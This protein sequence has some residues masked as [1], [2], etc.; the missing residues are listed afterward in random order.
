MKVYRLEHR[1]FGK[2]P[3][4]A[5]SEDPD[6]GAAWELAGEDPMMASPSRPAPARDLGFSFWWQEK[7]RIRFRC[8]YSDL[9]FGCE[10][11]DAL[12]EWFAGE[13]FDLLLEAGH[14]IRI[15]DVPEEFV[16]KGGKQ[17]AFRFMDDF[18]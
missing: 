6:T 4:T 1:A 9:L 8:G 14:E 17:L 12:K 3:H 18:E 16:C 5:A 15:Y 13:L 11:L 2:G 7:L 10:S